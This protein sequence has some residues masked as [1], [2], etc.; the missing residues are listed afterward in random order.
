MELSEIR[1]AL[2]PDEPELTKRLADWMLKDV[3]DASR[4]AAARGLGKMKDGKTASGAL[5]QALRGDKERF[6]RQMAATVLGELDADDEVAVQALTAA[7]TD[8]AAEVR[9]AAR[10]A[11]AKIKK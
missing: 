4:L 8:K 11:L 10:A 3:D 2:G 5:A 9:E 1:Q 6:V 7:K